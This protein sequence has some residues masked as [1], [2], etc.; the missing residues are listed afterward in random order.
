[1]LI[2]LLSLGAGERRKKPVQDPRHV[3]VGGVGWTATSFP[4]TKVDGQTEVTRWS[5]GTERNQSIDTK[6]QVSESNHIDII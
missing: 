6:E 1:M 3:G 2:L 4:P 5:D